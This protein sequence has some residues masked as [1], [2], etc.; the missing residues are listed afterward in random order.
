MTCLQC[1]AVFPEHDNESQIASISGSIMGDEYTDLYYLCNQCGAYTVETV[2]EPFLGDEQHTVKGP[3]PRT[4]G[5]AKVALIRQCQRPWDK[6]CR[7]TF[8]RAYFGDSL[9]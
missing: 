3:I 1:G 2:Y 5:D 4:E 8:H 9:D 6:K 7:C